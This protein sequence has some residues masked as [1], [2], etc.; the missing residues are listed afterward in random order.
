[1]RGATFH[2]QRHTNATFDE[3]SW[4]LNFIL[5]LVVRSTHLDGCC[6]IVLPIRKER[7]RGHRFVQGRQYV[8]AHLN[9]KADRSVIRKRPEVS[10]ASKGCDTDHS[11]HH[12]SPSEEKGCIEL[13][14]GRA[15]HVLRSSEYRC[16]V[17]VH[18]SKRSSCTLFSRTRDMEVQK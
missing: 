10:A 15:E 16:S 8:T 12:L 13:K 11:H 17:S 1:V 7:Q 18:R 3:I 6:H 14:S 5:P 4:L 2:T 9:R